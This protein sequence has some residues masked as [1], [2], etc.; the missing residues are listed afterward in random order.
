MLMLIGDGKGNHVILK[1][2]LISEYSWIT[3]RP[4]IA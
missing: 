3:S 2:T 4:W 1:E